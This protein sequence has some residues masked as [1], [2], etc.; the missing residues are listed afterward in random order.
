MTAQAVFERG[1]TDEMLPE[2]AVGP[3][4]MTLVD[5]L[6]AIGFAHS[7]KDARRLISQGGV[8]LA[9]QPVLDEGHL[10]EPVRSTAP[11]MI[12][13]G[14]KRHGVLVAA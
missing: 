3:T 5:A 1:D 12:S 8:R 13:A 14:K 7:K 10:I 2:L 9:N 4:G 11:V 6:I